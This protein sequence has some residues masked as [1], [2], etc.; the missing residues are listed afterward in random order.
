MTTL[1]AN[2]F[3]LLREVIN[4]IMENVDIDETPSNDPLLSLFNMELYEGVQQPE[5]AI[6][7][8]FAYKSN[9]AIVIGDLLAYES[10][11]RDMET[12]RIK[13]KFY[14]EQVEITETEYNRILANQRQPTRII[15]RSV[16]D[17]MK[18]QNRY[19]LK[20]MRNVAING[21]TSGENEDNEVKIMLG[22]GT[23][24]TLTDPY[25][26]NATPG[27]AYTGTALIF[28]GSQQTSNNV[29]QLVLAA[30]KGMTVIDTTT[31]DVIPITN[32]Y[33]GMDKASYAIISSNTEILN[34]TTGQRSEKTMLQLFNDMGV[35]VV[36]DQRFDSSH[37]GKTDPDTA[38]WTFFDNPQVNCFMFV[39]PDGL[40][41]EESWTNWDKY[42][43]M[44]KDGTK[45]SLVFERHKHKE[46]GF[47]PQAYWVQSATA[48]YKTIW[49][50]T[51]TTF[52][53]TA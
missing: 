11:E 19:F 25:D 51:V 52:D 21:L 33:L 36:V 13:A 12:G 5:S 32:L 23:S 24:G 10:G 31:D 35:T 50:A 46:I 28:S 2:P 22:A 14:T 37:T 3:T 45:S 48:Y 42:R 8:V 20:E 38:T 44:N 4:P 53:D 40:G 47:W 1:V 9:P 17:Q 29:Q 34:D 15:E 18:R 16:E 7:D 30:K 6:I 39:V 27:T 26:M 43:K 41:E 49:R